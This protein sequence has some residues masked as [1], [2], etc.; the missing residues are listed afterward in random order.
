MSPIRLSVRNPVLANLLMITLTVIGVLAFI[1]LPRELMPKISFNWA[2]IITPYPNVPAEDV[3]QLVTIPIEEEIAGLD[4]INQ[5]TSV[6]SEGASFIWVKFDLM[7]EDKFSKRLADLKIEIDKAELPDDVEDTE[8]EELDTDD[9]IPI[10]SVVL[11][12]QYPE[13]VMKDISEDLSDLFKDVKGVSEV[14]V[15]GTREREIWVEVSPEK[16][17]AQG[18]SLDQVAGQI[19]MRNRNLAGGDLQTGPEKLLVRTVGEFEDVD[20]IRSGVILKSGVDGHQVYLRDVATISDRWEEE[21]TRSRING[22]PAVTLSIS[23]KAGANSLEVIK[24]IKRITDEYRPKLPPG[25]VVTYTN[26]NS[27]SINDVLQKLQNNALI[28]L[29]LV[30]VILWVTLGWRNA[31]ITA[32]GIPVTLAIT[33]IFLKYS[34]NTLNGSALFGLVLVLGMLVDDAIVVME[35]CFRYLQ[36]GLKPREAV[37]KGAHEVAAPVIASVFTTIAAFLPLMLLPGIMGRFMR[38]VPIV[39][40]LALLASLFECFFILPSHVAEWSK[41]NHRS[42]GKWAAIFKRIPS[43]YQRLLERAMRRR[44]LIAVI[45]PF[46]ILISAG[47][48]PLIGVELYRDEEISRFSVRI[49][50]PE[51]TSLDVTDQVISRIER[52]AMNLPASE[53]HAIVATP[54]M[55][56]AE[57]EWLF[58]SS[59]GQVVVDLKERQDRTMPIDD[60]MNMLRER[61]EDIPG[62]ESIEFAKVNTGPP[63]GKA[64]EVRVQGKYYEQTEAVAEELKTELASIDGVYDISD[65]YNPGKRQVK[66]KVDPEKAALFGLSVTQVGAS[67]AAAFDGIKASVLRDGDDEIDIRVKFPEERLREISDVTRLK[68][69]L[70][71]GSWVP[72]ENLASITVEHGVADI[73]HFDQ[74]RAI[75]VSANVDKKKVS[76]VD[77]NQRLMKRFKDVE[78]YYP[79]VRMYFGGEFAEF[80]EAFSGLLELFMIGLGLIYIILGTQFRSF[81]QPILIM[82][83]IPF[84]FIGAMIG[85]LLSGNPFSITTLYGFVALAG[86]VVN[87]SIVLVS[88]INSARSNGI[89]KHESIIQAGMLRMRPIIMTSLTTIFGLLPMAIGLGGR[90]EVWGPLANTIVWGLAVSTFLT[91]LV[92]PSVYELVVDDIGGWF[93]RKFGARNGWVKNNV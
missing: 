50:M 43:T 10:I 29:I 51:G 93:R 85:L 71:D 64:V 81:I 11:S 86:I 79:G 39:V 35:N 70:P 27:I 17:Y 52:E 34:G 2:F 23:K 66:V 19:I 91:L 42:S 44:K 60:L 12:G 5:I 57:D 8:V 38:I 7:S 76:S 3:E 90:S 82:I 87:N 33:M 13:R 84:A 25:M 56:L 65:N 31:L 74:D 6:S 24:Q 41:S 63:L 45:M 22:L 67:I 54:G 78:D 18:L 1:D 47:L 30:I 26:D 58:K 55:F 48:I 9:F 49:K 14:A 53:L 80:R 92:V 68:F 16:L 89:G 69:L 32:I 77:V 20:E 72:F 46:I 61:T 75:T 4:G 21:R 73:R 15:A 40:S 36:Q 62:I 59:V 83:A 88:F 28:G 37:L